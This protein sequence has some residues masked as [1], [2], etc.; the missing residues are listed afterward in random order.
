ME[1][2]LKSKRYHPHIYN[3][4]SNPYKGWDTF[5][6]I[7]QE[8]KVSLPPKDYYYFLCAGVHTRAILDNIEV[9]NTGDQDLKK[10]EISFTAPMSSITRS[11]EGNITN[12]RVNQPWCF[13]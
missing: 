4:E 9:A 3:F 10:I 11:R 8:L 13:T 1:S 7:A 12:I 6:D 5:R 2:L